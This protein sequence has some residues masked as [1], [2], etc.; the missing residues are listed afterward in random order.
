MHSENALAESTSSNDYAAALTPLAL[1]GLLAALLGQPG[2]Q[3]RAPLPRQASA[4]H[5]RPNPPPP[6]PDF[7]FHDTPPTEIYSLTLHYAL[8]SYTSLEIC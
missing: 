2:A 5:T 3:A 7:F 6:T 1:P 8:P 4:P